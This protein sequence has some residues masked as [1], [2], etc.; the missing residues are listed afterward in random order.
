MRTGAVLSDETKKKISEKKKG[1]RLSISRSVSEE[2]KRKIGCANRISLQGRALAEEHKEKIRISIRK[3]WEE[4][5]KR[6]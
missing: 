6:D 1:V 3:Y 2:T 4:R 5:N